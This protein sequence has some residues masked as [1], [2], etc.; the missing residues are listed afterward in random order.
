MPFF[1]S[2]FAA[3]AAF[4]LVLAAAPRAAQAVDLAA[5][6]RAAIETVIQKQFD[7]FSRGDSDAAFAQ[8]APEIRQMFGEADT[9]MRMVRQSY[10]PVYHHRDAAF[11]E[12]KDGPTQIVAITDDDGRH[13]LAFYQMV[14]GEDG[15]WRIKGCNLIEDPDQHA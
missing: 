9:F 3:L 8:A 6:E 1:K 14:Q 12:I 11:V 13:W 2:I 10:A 7:A 15:Q 4:A 5:P